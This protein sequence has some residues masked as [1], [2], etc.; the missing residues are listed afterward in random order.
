VNDWLA[1]FDGQLR[2]DLTPPQPGWIVER[3]GRVKRC[4]AP[5]GLQWG[6]YVEWSD[7]TSSTA[8]DEIAAQVRHFGSLGRR[9]EWKTYAYDEPSELPDLLLAAGFV[10]EQTEALVVGEVA[11]VLEACG[12]P[13][14]PPGVVV[15]H[16]GDG[17]WAG[18]AALHH[19][20]WDEDHSQ[21]VDELRAEIANGSTGPRVHVAEA[22]GRIVSAAWV[23]FHDGTD[24]ASLWG[25]STLA[26]WRG[27]GIY[28][29]LVRR[30]AEEA[31]ERGFTLLQV[32]ASPD[33]RPILERLGM[34]V[35]T[36][37]TPYV[38]TPPESTP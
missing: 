7:L 18:I 28:R 3:V 21:A 25:G 20:V 24:F 11:T 6:N 1:R 23:R 33:S 17:D 31:R 15:R 8:A 29:A 34:R 35:L 36:T 10:P 22:D 26:A 16:V 13:P 37:T 32:D 30:R 4:T 12:P 38:W 2:Q 5:E 19:E 9:F 14:A 27:R